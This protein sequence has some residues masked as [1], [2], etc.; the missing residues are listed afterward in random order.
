MTDRSRLSSHSRL[1]SAGLQPCP[2]SPVPDATPARCDM[3]ALLHLRAVS[4]S[5]S[6]IGLAG[7]DVGQGFSPADRLQ[8][9]APPHGQRDTPSRRRHGGSHIFD[10]L[11][12]DIR[13]ALRLMRKTPAFTA[14]TLG[15][16]RDLP[17]RQPGHLCG[18]RLGAAASAAVR[19]ERAAG[20]GVQHVPEGGR[21]E[22]RRVAD[23]LL[24]AP[25]P[26]PRLLERCDP[27]R[28]RGHR[29]RER[30]RPSASR[31]RES[32]PSS[33]R[34]SVCAPSSA[35][36]S[37]RPRRRYQTDGVAIVTDAVLAACARRRRGRD[38]PPHPRG[39]RREDHRRSAA[40]RTSRSCRR[41]RVSI[42]RW[43]RIPT[44]AAPIG[45]TGAAR[46]R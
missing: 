19:R 40:A 25:R 23:E 3:A 43:R 44:S 13:Y 27:P 38:R 28:R 46:R 34:P 14:T 11:G 45:G 21:P 22:R 12:Q 2:T 5:T 6:L 16:D 17:R 1:V 41:R 32:R 29:G 10:V 8:E 7:R 36:R 15:H 20:Q 30:S 9:R 39:R 24:R 31:L 18:R 42:S 26:Y 37:R 35:G 33:L 4:R